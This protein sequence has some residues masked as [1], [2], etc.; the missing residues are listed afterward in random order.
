MLTESIIYLLLILLFINNI[1]I[2]FIINIYYCIYY[3]I[4]YYYVYLLL[5]IIIYC[6][7]EK[8]I[9]KSVNEFLL[10]WCV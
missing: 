4:Y 7:N 5:S 9:V 2:V 6:M 8:S 3:C 1:S 10:L